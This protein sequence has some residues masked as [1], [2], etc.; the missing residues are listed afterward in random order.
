MQKAND[1][2]TKSLLTTL[3]EELENCLDKDVAALQ[4]AE[5]KVIPRNTKNDDLAYFCNPF[6][7]GLCP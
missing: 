4:R 3:G 6:H 1:D 2:K 7:F 5:T